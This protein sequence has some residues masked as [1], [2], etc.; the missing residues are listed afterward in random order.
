MASPNISFDSIPSSIR[1]PG[2]YFEFNNRLAV[3]T[4]P[5]NLRRVL[6]VAQMLAAGTAVANQ[7]VQVFDAETAATLFGRGSQAH[8]MVKAAI[9]A[10]PYLQLYVLPVADSGTG[11]AATATLTYTGPA[12]AGGSTTVKIGGMDLVVPV[13]N[14]DSATAIAT[15]VVA[16]INGTGK[17]LGVTAANAAGVVTL[18]ARNKGLV[19]NSVPLAATADAVGTTVAVVAFSGG[20]NDPDLAAPL[21]A[22]QQGGHE[23]LVVPYQA[24]AP[25]VQLRT[26]LAF[27][28]G[29]MEQR[30]AIGI[31]GTNGTLSAATTLAGGLNAERL[32]HVFLPGTNTPAPE[33]A[34][35]YAAVVAGEEDPAKPLNT[36]ELVGIAV[37]PVAS[38]LTRTEQ[39]SCLNNGVT[40]LEV[41]PGNRVQIVRAITT[42]TLNAQAISDISWL[43]LTTIQTMDFVAKACRERIALRFPRDK[44]S[45]KT[46]DRIRSELYDV[47]LK[48]EELEIV[49]QVEENKNG[50]I[51]E[52]DS[53][54][55]NRCNARI[56]VDVVNGL[57]VF[58]GRLDL[59]L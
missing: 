50:L 17:D 8:R 32:N 28:S 20:L 5:S 41:G 12:T 23:I 21:A 34:A 44:L 54:D 47:L 4:L 15:A 49:E 13:A 42:Y 48:L 33:L 59:L 19:G 38:Q 30:R 6:I 52:R 55:P 53:Q 14:G 46:P 31:Y 58:A 27:V 37:P 18:T 29:P 43:D 39:E 45:A 24:N 56:P 26:H 36:L 2:K 51:V 57:H 11:V 9:K 22:V 1:K 10:N 40:P 16:V 7:A 3:R 25:L 35:A